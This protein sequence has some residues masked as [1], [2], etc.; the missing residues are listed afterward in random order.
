MDNYSESYSEYYNLLYQSDPE[1]AKKFDEI[2]TE[3]FDVFIPKDLPPDEDFLTALANGSFN[4]VCKTNFGIGYSKDRKAFSVAVSLYK[5]CS[6][7]NFLVED[8]IYDLTGYS[9]PDSWKGYPYS[10]SSS[11]DEKRYIITDHIIDLAD[12]AIC[13]TSNNPYVRSCKTWFIKNGERSVRDVLVERA[14]EAMPDYFW[15]GIFIEYY[16]EDKK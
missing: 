12:E 10:F 15:S 16:T 14:G 1:K 6:E 7:K 5:L 2:I 8:V 3:L 4:S 9:A 13:L 11:R